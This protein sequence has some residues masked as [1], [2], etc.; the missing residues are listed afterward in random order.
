MT[1]QDVPTFRDFGGHPV[2]GGGRVRRGMLYRSAVLAELGA[3][4]RSVLGQMGVRLVCDLRSARER[5][6]LPSLDWLQPQPGRMHCDVSAGF[7]PGK[8]PALELLRGETGE[9]AALDIMKVTYASLPAASVGHLRDLLQR[10]AG[11]EVPAIIHCS[12][13]KDRTGFFCAAV[14]A[15]LGVGRDD[16]YADYLLESPAIRRSRRARTTAMMEALAGPAVPPRAIE[17]LSGVEREYLDV[18]FAAID[19]EFGGVESYLRE[20]LGVDGSLGS[21]LRDRLVEPDSVS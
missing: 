14:L 10:L 19:R 6:R 1:L 17:I 5:E 4:D 21:A 18:A 16:I 20:A 8:L 7:R 2:Q 9:A 15:A 12:A 3:T 13:G 11:G